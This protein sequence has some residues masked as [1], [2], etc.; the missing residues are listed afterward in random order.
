MRVQLKATIPYG[1]KFSIAAI[2]S[3][4]KIIKYGESIGSANTDIKAGDYV[5]VHN[6]TSMRGSDG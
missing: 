1:H 4:A 2:K 3:G 5:H 6:L